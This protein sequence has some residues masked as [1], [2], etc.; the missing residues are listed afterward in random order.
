MGNLKFPDGALSPHDRRR[1]EDVYQY[2]REQCDTFIGYPC[3]M[4]FDYT[5]LLPFLAYPVNNVGDPF[6]ASSYR[7]H[8]REI[9]REVLAWFAELMHIAP[10]E[11]WG[12]VTNG[13]TEG[14]LYGLFLAR[15]RFPTGVAYYSEDTHY[16]VYKNLRLLNMRH[17]MIKS[18]PNGEI[19]YGDLYETMR[20]HRDCPPIIFANIG[21]TMTEGIDNVRTIQDMFKKLAIHES[22][23]HCDAA[24]AGMTLPFMDDA[25]AFDFATGIDSLSISGHKFIG[26]P[27]PCGIV[28]TRKHYVERIARSIEYV[29]TLDT[30]ITGSRNG[31]TPL[32]L[33]YAVKQAGR[34]GFKRRVAACLDNARYTVEQFKRIGVE[35][36]RNPC[37]ITVVFPKPPQ[38]VLHKWQIAV[39][40]DRAHIILMPST[41]LQHVDELIADIAAANKAA[42]APSDTQKPAAKKRPTPAGAPQRTT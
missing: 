25:P 13:G 4:H 42:A 26:S 30:T 27:I 18:Q 34:D 15:E 37:A 32:F 8:T 12:Y 22:H 5:P 6:A 24:L 2:V 40:G 21:T 19:D 1:L 11:Y 31:I 39:N 14:N 28:L 10:E 17:I 33:W 29:G 38:S 35:A 3:T 20:I 16:S 41:T 36:R 23:I 7:V 9:E